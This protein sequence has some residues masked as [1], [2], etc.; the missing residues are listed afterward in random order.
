M[1]WSGITEFF[2][3]LRTDR[4][5]DTLRQWNLGE[6]IATPWFLGSVLALALTA[7]FLRRRMLLAIILGA[8]GFAW[9]TSYTLE[10]GTSL[11]GG[12]NEGL[13]VFVGGGVV[14]VG[15]V[16]YLVFIRSD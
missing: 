1:D 14:L 5:L 16:L 11:E 4:I 10:R 15:V 12:S 6:L 2:R 8:A 3:H 7:F 9:L 13:L